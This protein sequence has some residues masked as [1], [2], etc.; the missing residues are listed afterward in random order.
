[1]VER[2][3]PRR[4][5]LEN[6]ATELARQALVQ[7]DLL[8]GSAGPVCA[9]G[10]GPSL[11]FPKGQLQRIG[12]PAALVGRDHDPIHHQFNRRSF[13]PG[14]SNSRSSRLRTSPAM[15][16]RWK[17][18]WRNRGNSSRSTAALAVITGA[19][20]IT[21]WPAALVRSFATHSSSVC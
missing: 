14:G 13:N 6:V 12:E 2:K 21:R 9:S 3:L 7:R 8:P 16:T 20:I 1:V 19:R 15:R 5:L 18:R 4:E 17:P 11:P 10:E